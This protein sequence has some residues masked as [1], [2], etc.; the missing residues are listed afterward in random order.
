[1]CLILCGSECVSLNWALLF[2]QHQHH[3]REYTLTEKHSKYR[4]SLETLS[5]SKE[6]GQGER[7]YIE[8]S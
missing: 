8:L 6:E 7:E 4:V 5:V 1:M 3:P 2:G